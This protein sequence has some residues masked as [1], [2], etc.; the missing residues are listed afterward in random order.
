MPMST[1]M[2]IRDD[3]PSAEPQPERLTR[4]EGVVGIAALAASAPALASAKRRGNRGDGPT[5]PF[6][7]GVP[8]GPTEGDLDADPD[9]AA[10]RHRRRKGA[11]GPTGQ[12]GPTGASW[13]PTGPTGPAGPIGERGWPG[14]QGAPG[15]D[16]STGPTGPS[17]DAPVVIGASSFDGGTYLYTVSAQDNGTVQIIKVP[18][19]VGVPI[20]LVRVTIPA[21]L[22]A[23]PFSAHYVVTKTIPNQSKPTVEVT[24]AAKSA[25]LNWQPVNPNTQES[26][27]EF[28]AVATG[29]SFTLR[30][31]GM[32][33]ETP[34]PNP[35]FLLEY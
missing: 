18:Q 35:L 5:G 26:K 30:R 3:E 27:I 19:V 20:T 12:P 2:P 23:E 25:S 29:F 32:D 11:T 6:P 22:V 31:F 33:D 14:P 24:V 4:R 16:G 10:K 34:I 13:M 15:I 21:T 9:A 7:D 28:G 8:T 1:L 17:S